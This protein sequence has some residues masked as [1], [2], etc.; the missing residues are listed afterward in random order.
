MAW[1][2]P[3]NQNNNNQPDENSNYCK[4]ALFFG[5]ALI[6]TGT[7]IGVVVWLISRDQ[8]DDAD[9][10][11]SG[12]STNNTIGHEIDVMGVHNETNDLVGES[13]ND[14]A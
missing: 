13:M 7:I 8:G 2:V 9:T 14:I 3:T 12:N 11:N 10:H 4:A 1:A 6:I 5:T